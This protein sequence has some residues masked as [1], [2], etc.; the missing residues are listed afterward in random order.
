MRVAQM[1]I[2]TVKK[3]KLILVNLLESFKVIVA[4]LIIKCRDK[5][6]LKL[7]IKILSMLI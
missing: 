7:T 5:Y 4:F 1:P 3:P 2:P 6:T